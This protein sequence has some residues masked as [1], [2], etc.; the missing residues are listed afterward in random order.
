V[1]NTSTVYQVFTLPS[2][3]NP[4]D[5]FSF[6]VQ[7]FAAG[8]GSVTSRDSSADAISHTPTSPGEKVSGLTATAGTNA[9]T[10]KWT[11]APAPIVGQAIWYSVRFKPVSSSTW[12]YTTDYITNSADMTPLT[13]G[14]AYEFEVAVTDDATVVSGNANWSAAVDK[15][16]NT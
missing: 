4:G 7:A 1:S 16:P 2:G 10:L 6:W 9:V 15:T 12:T 13:G 3:T 14:T 8:N 5:K 11:A